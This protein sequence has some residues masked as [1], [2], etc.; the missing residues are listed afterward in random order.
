MR[1][2][3]AALAGLLLTAGAAAQTRYAGLCDASAGVALDAS[4]FIV[5]DDERNTLVIYRRDT[6]TAV[7][8][9]ELAAFL[10][11]ERESDLEGAAQVGARIYW[12][13]SHARNSQGKVRPDRQRI[14]AT[15]IDGRAQPPT[16][17]PVG[18]P[19][20]HL[21]RDL[22][23]APALAAWKLAD[24]AEL[25]P[26]ADGGFNIEGLAA[27]PEGSLLIGLRNP[28]REG[29]ALL[30]PL[31]NPSDLL[32]GRGPA[33]FGPVMTLNLAGRG[34]RSIER[35]SGAYLI[36]AGPTADTGNFALYRWSGQPSEA[37]T[38][39][40]TPLG[41]LRPEG[42]FAWPSGQVTLVSDD[43]GV[44]IGKTECKAAA[45]EL[46]GFRTLSLPTLR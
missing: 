40:K 8:R 45:P 35:V 31:L 38:L 37:P 6:P 7:G 24:A 27:G 20:E 29:R 10:K 39:V 5:A 9:V 1:A 23:A 34:I 42:L 2:L 32:D 41:T 30:I 14:F 3:L 18:R 36:V 21:L 46:R 4:H 26:E 16:V 19:Y 11:T 33:R 22:L 43:G 25:A 17:R 28:L 44:K 13:A 15:D 12:I